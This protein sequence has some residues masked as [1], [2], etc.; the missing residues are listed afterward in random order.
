MPSNSKYGTVVPVRVMKVY[1]GSKGLVPVVLDLDTTWSW[2][3]NFT[4]RPETNLCTPFIRGW[5]G[6]KVGLGRFS[7]EKTLSHAGI[8]KPDRPVRSFTLTTLS[9]L[10]LI[11]MKVENSRCVLI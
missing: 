11:K 1:V 3:V 8:R 9:W 5:V 4:S 6:P 2:V 10:R 7:E